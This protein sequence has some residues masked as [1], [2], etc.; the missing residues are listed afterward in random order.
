MK[1]LAWLLTLPLAVAV[2]VFAVHNRGPVSIDPWPL[3][4]PFAMPLYLL[5]LG[6]VVLGFVA[7][8][9]VQWA[10]GGKR[11]SQARR[12]NRRLNE[13]ERAAGAATSKAANSAS[14]GAPSSTDTRLLTAAE[15]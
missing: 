9:L 8:A 1:R 2:V 4:Q 6:A 11:R 15:Q 3:D 12:N 13:L 5:G 10:A 7:G 14:S